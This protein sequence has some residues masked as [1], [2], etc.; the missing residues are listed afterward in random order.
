MRTRRVLELVITPEG[1]QTTL[2]ADVLLGTGNTP[3]AALGDW[4]GWLSLIGMV[5]IAG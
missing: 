4:L 1:S 5:F 3:C 2:I